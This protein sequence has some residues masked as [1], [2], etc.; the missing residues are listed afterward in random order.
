M[1]GR[2]DEFVKGCVDGEDE[3]LGAWHGTKRRRMGRC[4]VSGFRS[5]RSVEDHIISIY[6]PIDMYNS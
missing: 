6:L 1:E 3:R 5:F 2:F 4:R